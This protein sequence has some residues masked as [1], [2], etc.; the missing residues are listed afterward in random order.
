LKGIL[1][2][3]NHENI[4]D[5][6]KKM[7]EKYLGYIIRK[8][9]KNDDGY[10]LIGRT[11]LSPYPSEIT[12]DIHREFITNQNECSLFGIRLRVNSLPFHQQ[13]IAVGA[14][15]SA[16]LWMSQFSIKNWYPIP[17]KS[18]AEITEE[19]QFYYRYPLYP[20]E[21]LTIDEMCKYL[22]SIGLHFHTIEILE[23]Y[24][25][26][27]KI[28]KKREVDAYINRLMEDAIRAYF[29]ASFSIICCLSLINYKETPKGREITK[30]TLHAVILSGYKEENRRIVEL[31]L[32][33]D[34]IGPYCKTEFLEP[35]ILLKNEWKN[36][37]DEIRIHTILIPIDPMIKLSFTRIYEQYLEKI[38]DMIIENQYEDYQILLSSINMYK[39]KLM[40]NQN[41]KE[42]ILFEYNEEEMISKEVTKDILLQKN[43]P[44]YLWIIRFFKGNNKI[45]DII[46]DGTRTLWHKIGEI[47]YDVK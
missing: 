26:L 39:E 38:I 24:K 4:K 12:D 34:K 6:I 17:I 30:K 18:L 21:G 16:A 7:N 29:S 15:A 41:I 10:Y 3:K 35:K 13:D 32:H 28:W 42:C 5:D 33:D 45:K 23:L 36:K 27:N 46:L 44:K 1:S 47:T 43:F 22:S 31:Y 19:S 37:W 40:S 8:P 25:E 11:C 2:G 14:C 20:S 9:V